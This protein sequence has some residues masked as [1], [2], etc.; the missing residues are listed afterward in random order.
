IYKMFFLCEYVSGEPKENTEVSEIDF[1]AQHKIPP[2][3]QSRVLPRDI[4]MVFDAFYSE[5]FQVHVD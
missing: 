5:D 3:S 1:F 4:E 2:L